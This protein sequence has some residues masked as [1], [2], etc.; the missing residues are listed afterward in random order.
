MA[1]KPRLYFS[2]GPVQG[3]VAQSR[4]TRDLWAGSYL[5]SHLIRA[6]M[7]VVRSSRGNIILPHLPDGVAHFGNAPNRFVAEAEDPA[8]AGVLAVAALQAEWQKIATVVWD[9]F[10]KDAGALGNGTQAI[11][12]RQVSNFW[13]ISWLVSKQDELPRRKNWRNTPATV[14]AGDHCTMMNEWQELSGFVRSR[15]H[16]RDKQ[17][18]FWSAVRHPLAKLD[19][20]DDERL[21]A[22]ALIKRLVPR[23][24]REVMGC[25]LEPRNWPSTPYIAA[26]PWL[27]Q[28]GEKSETTRQTA[29]QYGEHVQKV[30]E[31]ALGN[32]Y[33]RIPHL[34]KLS[35]NGK[36]G[37]F[38]ELDG[39][40]FHQR[41]LINKRVTPLDVAP[42]RDEVTRK[43]L[44]REL[45]KL[46]EL[47][48]AAP[49]PFYAVLLMD[50]DST[51][52][53]LRT[54]RK[55][56]KE[57]QATKALGEFSQAV[58]DI[59][60]LHDGV[61]VYAGGDDVLAMV[62]FDTALSCAIALRQAYADR[63]RKI[64]TATISASIVFADYHVPLRE[65]LGRGHHLLDA[66]AKDATGRDSVAIAVLKGSGMVAQWSAPWEHICRGEQNLLDELAKE[67]TPG[68]ADLPVERSGEFST[69]FFYN[70]RQRFASL[71]DSP[72]ST[73]G[74]FGKLVE[75]IEL[76]PLLLA[77]H[78]RSLTHRRAESSDLS[79]EERAEASDKVRRLLKLCQRV[80]R[81]E[82]PAEDAEPRCQVHTDTLGVDG[83][84]LLRFLAAAGRE[85]EQ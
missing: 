49:S 79:H 68:R 36:F 20:D 41:A 70:V 2:I 38:F 22:I 50:G 25:S 1:E 6:A 51:G 19:L 15:R 72:L 17:E 7:N 81:I 29:R 55:E 61:T 73:P 46:S 48:A 75:G 45:G 85:D 56:G 37:R 47:V 27:R 60:A 40:F 8:R 54:A 43:Q 71:T 77:E 74:Q 3:F 18:Q 64:A 35:E 11:W 4:R 62:A 30:A 34:K 82:V 78:L 33:S 9:S 66:V 32:R 16:E 65:V 80:V 69:G 57:G 52:K 21:C 13:E 5:L 23:V 26:V 63:F 84:M 10:L 83:L 28:L 31:Q 39:N 44:R 76:E 42:D 67:L 53:L 59:V 24:A 12:H 14:E 58:P